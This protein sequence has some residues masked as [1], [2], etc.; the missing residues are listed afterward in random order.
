MKDFVNDFVN[1]F[2]DS[3]NDSFISLVI[4]NLIFG[5]AG[6]TL[7]NLTHAISKYLSNK[8]TYNTYN[9]YID[10][11]IQILLCSILLSF[12]RL[13]VMWQHQ[14]YLPGIFFVTLYFNAQKYNFFL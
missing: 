3:Y 9:V 11:F 14:I 2:I 5:L 6:F 8:I 10:I 1:D 7:G 12:I 4:L 13:G